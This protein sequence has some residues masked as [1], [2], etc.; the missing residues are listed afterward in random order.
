MPLHDLD[1]VRG[2]AHAVDEFGRDHSPPSR[3]FLNS[4]SKRISSALRMGAGPPPGRPPW[5]RLSLPRCL[6]S[7][8][9][10]SLSVR[11]QC[12]LGDSAAAPLAMTTAANP[13]S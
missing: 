7:S 6:N 5:R 8:C 2:V 3:A 1:D 13:K 4:S 11:Y 12:P 9:S 10:A